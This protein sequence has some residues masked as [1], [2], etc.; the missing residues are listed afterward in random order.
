MKHKILITGAGG[1]I[2]RH[3]TAILGK[4]GH[5]VM[6]MTHK[7]HADWSSLKNVSTCS[8]NLLDKEGL[9]SIVK[10]F[11]PDTVIHLAAIASPV[12]NDIL[13]IFQTNVKGSK[14]LLDGLRKYCQPGTRVVLTSTAGVYGNVP[15]GN[16][17]ESAPFSP[18]NYYGW[19]KMAMEVLARHYREFEIRIL[20][21]F[22]IIGVGQ[23][24]NFLI[25]KLVRAFVLR[26]PVLKV[27]DLKTIRDYT[28]ILFCSK[29]FVQMALRNDGPN[30]TLNVC[31]GYGTTGVQIVEYLHDITGYSPEIVVDKSLLRHGEIMRLVGDNNLLKS[32]MCNGEKPL[33]VKEILAQMVMY[34][35]QQEA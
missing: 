19:S 2:G 20:R 8:T 13:E 14:N 10:S 7:K 5:D 35:E 30:T 34:S 23:K 28:D 4:L 3:V 6:A 31:S 17:P 27:G 16:I 29:V 25:P 1:F 21:P 24:E 9:E 12:H 32:F 33:E 22:N 26:K 11:V 18:L 15:R